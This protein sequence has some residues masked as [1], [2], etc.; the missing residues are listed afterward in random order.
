MVKQNIFMKHIHKM[1]NKKLKKLIKNIIKEVSSFKK[2]TQINEAQTWWKYAKCDCTCTALMP[3]ETIVNYRCCCNGAGNQ[4]WRRRDCPK[5]PRKGGKTGVGEPI[6]IDGE[7]AIIQTV[8][9]DMDN[10]PYDYNREAPAD[11]D[12]MGEDLTVEPDRQTGQIAQKYEKCECTCTTGMPDGRRVNYV[13][14]C[15]SGAPC[16]S[17]KDCPKSGHIDIGGDEDGIRSVRMPDGQ[18]GRLLSV[19]MRNLDYEN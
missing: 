9:V 18:V 14:C 2:P 8:Q 13:C 10:E 4:C 16:K 5:G 3:D 17:K 6:N 11:M 7:M 1:K 19:S 12:M 15:G